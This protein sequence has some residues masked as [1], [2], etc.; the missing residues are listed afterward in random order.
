MSKKKKRVAVKKEKQPVL[1]VREPQ[2]SWVPVVNRW[3]EEFE[4]YLWDPFRGF[5]WPTEYELPM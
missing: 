2:P 1:A 3:L 4:G 5:E